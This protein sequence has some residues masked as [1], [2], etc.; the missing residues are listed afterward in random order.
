MNINFSLSFFVIGT[1]IREKH[2]FAIKGMSYIDNSNVLIKSRRTLTRECRT[3]N[4]LE[5]N[6]FSFS[7]VVNILESCIHLL[8]TVW[9]Q[10]ILCDLLGGSSAYSHCMVALINWL[11]I[12]W[13]RTMKLSST[14]IQ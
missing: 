4:I 2:C 11:H 1:V 13:E 7:T 9:N 5:K 8:V 14:K 10:S 12:L 6:D 3:L